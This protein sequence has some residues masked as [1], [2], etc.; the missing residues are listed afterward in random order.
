M[1][2]MRKD[3]PGDMGSSHQEEWHQDPQRGIMVWG[4]FQRPVAGTKEESIK[5]GE[6]GKTEEGRR[7]IDLPIEADVA[8]ERFLKYTEGSEGDV[9]I[10]KRKEGIAKFQQESEGGVGRGLTY[11]TI[12]GSGLDVRKG[13]T[14]SLDKGSNG[15]PLGILGYRG[16]VFEE[17]S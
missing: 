16:E 17:E 11:E 13:K 8:F 5:E 10:K 7:A 12:F 9:P 4:S 1:F 14:G 3:I 2:P 6:R 15:G